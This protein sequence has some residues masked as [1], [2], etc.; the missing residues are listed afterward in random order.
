MS[1]P[2]LAWIRL[3]DAWVRMLRTTRPWVLAA[4][5]V[6]LPAFWIGC[7]RVGPGLYASLEAYDAAGLAPLAA[8]LAPCF[9]LT[10]FSQRI[11]QMPSRTGA[12]MTHDFHFLLGHPLPL[13]RVLMAVAA[14]WSFGDLP[15]VL[16]SLALL[17]GFLEAVGA[18]AGLRLVAGLLFL[19]MVF[20][21]FLALAIGRMLFHRFR[22]RGHRLAMGAAAL[23]L[24]ALVMGGLGPTATADRPDL[25]R[26]WLQRPMPAAEPSLLER[27]VSSLEPLLD[28]ARRLSPLAPWF[29]PFQLYRGAALVARGQAEGWWRLLGVAGLLA[30]ATLLVLAVAE[31]LSRRDLLA[32]TLPSS[33]EP[34]GPSTLGVAEMPER[35]LTGLDA[36]ELALWSRFA[37]G[38][39]ALAAATAWMTWKMLS[40]GYSILTAA[41]LLGM[42]T[43]MVGSMAG[44][45][46]SWERRGLVLC[47]LLP[48]TPAQIL[49]VKARWAALAGVLT[50]VVPFAAVGVLTDAEPFTELVRGVLVLTFLVF[51]AAYAG[52]A[53]GALLRDLA[54][55]GQPGMGPLLG[56][57]LWLGLCAAMVAQVFFSSGYAIFGGL[58]FDLLMVLA[59][60][61]RACVQLA[62]QH[63]LEEVTNE[64]T[65]FADAVLVFLCAYLLVT[66]IVLK[67]QALGASSAA[68]GALRTYLLTALFPLVLAALTWIHLRLLPVQAV[69]AGQRSS[70]GGDLLLAL[71]LAGC[72][73]SL[74]LAYSWGISRLGWVQARDLAA[75]VQMLRDM[76]SGLPFAPVLVL[77]LMG[78]LAPLAEEGFFRGLFYQ[79]IRRMQPHD[80][81]IAVLFSSL[82]FGLLHPAAHFPVIFTMGTL[83]AL[84]VE[85]RGSLRPAILAHALHN[86]T[87]VLLFLGGRT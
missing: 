15:V 9:W 1:A 71:G 55:Q 39:V 48:L 57:L 7:V 13:G 25:A 3:W 56:A 20:A 83:L 64:Q 68:V 59:L 60:W 85:R 18:P 29:P 77:A 73:V 62:H 34:V 17:A 61:Q 47:Q 75:G 33:E 28:T 21:V 41:K 2:R 30:L 69:P 4:Y 78:G 53:I 58:F 8:C 82:A 43:W 36:K 51:T 80:Y 11:Y 66:V 24:A 50:L 32:L 44:D 84:V 26:A 63:E 81:R 72:T 5:S 31:P 70:L 40:G 19:W 12:W 35:W 10:L 23:G 37:T 46:L 45:S 74:S 67:A 49:S 54:G 87:M 6:F 14:V 79:G 86:C 52:V 16:S 76:L 65:T 42:A 22:T 27:S 38:P